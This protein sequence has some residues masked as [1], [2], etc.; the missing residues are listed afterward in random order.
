MI[1]GLPIDIQVNSSVSIQQVVRIR[2]SELLISTVGLLVPT[3][4]I[5]ETLTF[6]V[7]LATNA[8]IEFGSSCFTSY[9]SSSF[10]SQMIAKSN[11]RRL[12]GMVRVRLQLLNYLRAVVS[13][14]SNSLAL[15]AQVAL[16]CFGVSRVGERDRF[17]LL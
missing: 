17:T 6:P 12:K 13:R 1:Y 5:Q 16:M 8:L 10:P 7:S 9:A 2:D 3:K 11:D 4:E 15:G 14:V